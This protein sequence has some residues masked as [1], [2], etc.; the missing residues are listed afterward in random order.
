[1]ENEKSQGIDGLTSNFY[2]HYWPILGDKLTRVCNHATWAVSKSHSC[3]V[4]THLYFKKVLVRYSRIGGRLYSLTTDYKILTKVLANG[5]QM[6]LPLII[7]T[8]Q[9]ATV[10]GRTIK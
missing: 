2:K 10:L 3:A 9:T 8:D 4:L 7:H 6:V 5:L 1:M